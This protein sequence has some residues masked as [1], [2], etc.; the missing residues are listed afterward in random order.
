MWRIYSQHTVTGCTYEYTVDVAVVASGFI[1][2]IV[3]VPAAMF[4]SHSLIQH[5]IRPFFFFKP[6]RILLY[7]KTKIPWHAIAVYGLQCLM[8]RRRNDPF[9]ISRLYT[10][11]MLRKCWGMWLSKLR[12]S[13]HVISTL[14]RGMAN[15]RMG[16]R[17]VAN[18]SATRAPYVRRAWRK[19]PM[20][21]KLEDFCSISNRT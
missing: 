2:C 14:R 12:V 9:P 13:R 21:A 11:Y 4:L 1:V 19:Q 16:D 10:V 18:L 20:G 7:K 15:S 17:T 8:P 5:N 3:I 6:R